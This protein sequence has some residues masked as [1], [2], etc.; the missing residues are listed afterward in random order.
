MFIAFG[1]LRDMSANVG[2]AVDTLPKVYMTD[3]ALSDSGTLQGQVVDL[4]NIG[5]TRRSYCPKIPKPRRDKN[6]YKHQWTVHGP[7]STEEYTISPRRKAENTFRLWAPRT[8]P[9]A[10]KQSAIVYVQNGGLGGGG[11][12][13][14]L[15]AVL[16]H[17]LVLP[18]VIATA[19]ARARCGKLRSSSAS[20]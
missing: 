13:G 9:P 5:Q 20:P 2:W 17:P 4:Q 8:A 10:A 3:V 14:G 19:I 18:A 11:G 12:S 6:G 7:G 1:N 15:K 16:G